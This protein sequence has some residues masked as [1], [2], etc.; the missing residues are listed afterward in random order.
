VNEIANVGKTMSSREIADLVELRHDNVKRTIDT[1]A[2][3]GVIV[4][5]QTE[6]VQVA[7]AMGR[8]RTIA[9]YRIG[10]RDSY[11]IVA[12]LSPEFTGRLVDRWQELESR[13]AAP[14]SLLDLANPT[15]VR[16]A[17]LVYTEKL[18]E[19]EQTIERQTP[20]VEFAHA[21]RDMEG[22]IDMARMARLIGWGRNT[23]FEA[24]RADKILMSNN[25]PYQ[26]YMDRRYFRVI[27]GTR[28]RSDGRIEPTFSTRVTGAGQV[29]LQHKYGK[30]T[31][32]A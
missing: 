31:E 21:I 2:L 27:E 24:L 15:S 7:D 14:T 20:A 32:T 8:A 13:T 4:H 16:A 6:D 23:L 22:S 17:L 25:L 18:I 3:R 12:Q 30:S 9:E 10:E 5:P 28:E 29:F 11:V 19:L 1:L 26:A